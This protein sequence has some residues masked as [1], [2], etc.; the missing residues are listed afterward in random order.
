[1]VQVINLYFIHTC[2]IFS[3]RCGFF[4]DTG[5]GGESAAAA[6]AASMAALSLFFL[7]ATMLKDHKM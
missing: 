7:M 3:L 6:A 1:M 4:E 2:V 5:V